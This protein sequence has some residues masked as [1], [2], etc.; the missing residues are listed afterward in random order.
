MKPHFTVHEL[1]VGGVEVQEARQ[2][3]RKVDV[4]VLVAGVIIGYIISLFL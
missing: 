2:C 3:S 4:A 1:E